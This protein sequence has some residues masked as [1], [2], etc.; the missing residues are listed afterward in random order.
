[1]ILGLCC[2]K[3]CERW[4]EKVLATHLTVCDRVLFLDDGSTDRTGE[5]AKGFDRV[6]YRRQDGLRRNEARDRNFLF[7]K[8]HAF[9]PDWCWWFDGDETLWRGERADIEKAG[10]EINTLSSRL[11]DL[12]GDERHYAADWSHPKRHIFRYLPSVCPGYSWTGRGR[13]QLHCGACP[14]TDEYQSPEH[15]GDTRIV[16]LHWSYMTPDMCA[17][18]L[19]QYKKWDA[20]FRDFKPYHR[21]EQPPKDVKRLEDLR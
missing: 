20:G 12:W 2:A 19:A 8:V 1:M 15:V 9:K 14:R 21:F 3:D 18:K 10:P 13:H 16:E 5:I 6:H 11:L 17:A 4:I 7:G